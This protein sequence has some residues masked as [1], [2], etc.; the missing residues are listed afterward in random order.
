MDAPTPEEV[1]C[2]AALQYASRRGSYQG[3]DWCVDQVV[4][5]LPEPTPRECRA[6]VVH[7]PESS[8]LYFKR[9]ARCFS[10]RDAKVVAACLDGLEVD[11][12]GDPW[13]I[14]GKP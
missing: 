2:V 10:E 3:W 6:Y 13:P 11:V 5:P 14:A 7:G 9:I 4:T 12:N 1:L 8:A